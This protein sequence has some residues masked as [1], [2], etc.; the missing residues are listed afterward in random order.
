MTTGNQFSLVSIYHYE[1][2]SV[3][4]KSPNHDLV[5]TNAVPKATSNKAVDGFKNALPPVAGTTE[6]EGVALAELPFP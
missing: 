4:A 2:M 3:L 6:A 1:F 5:V